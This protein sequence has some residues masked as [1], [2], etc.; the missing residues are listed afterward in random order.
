MREEPQVGGTGEG[1][2]GAKEARAIGR[3]ARAQE[4]GESEAR[5]DVGGKVEQWK[6]IMQ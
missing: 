3:A 6:E 1:R 5:E 2:E 4:G